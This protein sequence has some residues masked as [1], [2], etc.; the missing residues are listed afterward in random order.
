M[1]S[2]LRFQAQS[3]PEQQLQTPAPAAVEAGPV[4]ASST[5]ATSP[6]RVRES[7]NLLEADL[8]G[9]IADVGGAANRVHDSVGVS[10]QA[11][12]AIRVSTGGLAELV[13]TASANVNM[14]AGAT[15]QLAQSS[16]HIGE[17]IHRA[18]G[19]TDE[20]S[21][22]AGTTGKYVDN[23]RSSS[24]R[25]GSVVGLI[26]SI[27]KQTNLLAL[28]A[29]IEAARA[30]EAGRGFAVVASEVKALSAETQK[31]TDEIARQVDA[32]RKDAQDSIETLARIARLIEDFRPLY[33]TIAASVEQQVA[34]TS[35]L[36]KSASENSRFIA[37]VAEKAKSI[38]EAT[39][40]ATAEGSEID[41]SAATTAELAGTLRKRLSIFL[42]QT[43][44]GDRRR[45]ERLPCAL[46][47]R[48]WSGS[49]EITGEA[50]DLGEGGL[51]IK[52]TQG[53]GFSPGTTVSAELSEIGSIQC[54]IVNRSSL[55]MHAQFLDMPQQS[56]AALLDRLSSIRSDNHEF[57]ER[58]MATATEIASAFERL[59]EE[60]EVAE[61]IL[62]DNRYEQIAGTNPKQFR[63]PYL[64]LF[65]RVL[66]PIQERVLASDPRMIFCAAVDRNGYLPVHNLKY[67]EP[68][69]PDDLVWNAAHSRNRRIFDDRTGLCAARSARPYFIQ[70]YPRDMGGGVV[71][72]MKEIGSPIRVRGKHWGG[73]RT[74]Y[75][76]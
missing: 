73:F 58:A 55:G 24:A 18:T 5:A 43:E 19:L 52:L 51:L 31:A 8:A 56:R 13:D 50:V 39:S 42:R 72:W 47:I 4:G 32:L 6:E 53:E 3:Q 62:F 63:T 65:E 7:L 68:Q 64:P 75:K 21:D 44:I 76:I 34:T 20:A 26:S 27:A 17:Q 35:A 48:V 54:R 37:D 49:K 2:F 57:I 16:A 23:L 67:S 38:K 14:L 41:R 12:D 46:P 9:L 70:A 61:E 1:P 36:S 40:R 15:E 66:T 60:G 25:I 71:V 22:A 59:M 29:T 45:H 30:G 28:N 74:A 69:R 33:S 10:T 11:F